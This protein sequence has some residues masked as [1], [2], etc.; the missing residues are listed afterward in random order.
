[1][2]QDQE[3]GVLWNEALE[4]YRKTTDRNTIR[5]VGSLDELIAQLG[6]K[7]ENFQEYRRRHS[8]FL[9]FTKRCLQPVV[10]ISSIAQSAVGA[11]PFAPAATLIGAFV[12]LIRA[13]KGVSDAYDW[14]QS[15]LQ[16]LSAFTERLEVYLSE[17]IDHRLKRQLVTTLSCL[18]EIVGV[19]EN[20]VA[21]GRFKK[22]GAILLNG[23]DETAKAAFDRLNK[24][25]QNESR[26]VQALSYKATQ[27]IED[28]LNSISTSLGGK[29]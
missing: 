17:R 16:E 8:E 7:Q 21:S 18:L 27:N 12:Y 6:Q 20:T 1:M 29:Y 22:F 24:L 3:F 19:A 25:F 14:I 4:S 2:D 15:L 26:I 23:K 10:L 11:T 5:Q 28:Q 9:D 13:A